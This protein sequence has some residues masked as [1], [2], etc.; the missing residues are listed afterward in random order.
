MNKDKI[1]KKLKHKIDRLELQKKDHYPSGKQ[2]PDA[3]NEAYYNLG[4]L[5]GKIDALYMIL[6]MLE[7]D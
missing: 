1:V 7:G 6:E 5:E 3:N 4:Y 2:T